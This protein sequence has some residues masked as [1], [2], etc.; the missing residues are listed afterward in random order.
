MN[1][2]LKQSKICVLLPL[3]VVVLESTNFNILDPVVYI[4]LNNQC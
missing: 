2:I 3:V 1:F 4:Y